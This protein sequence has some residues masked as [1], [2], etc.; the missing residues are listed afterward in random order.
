MG[1]CRRDCAVVKE[2]Y[3]YPV[4][5]GAAV[6]ETALVLTAGEGISGD[7]HADGGERQISLLSVEEKT[8]MEQQEIK[9]FCFHK[10]KEN[11]LLDGICLKEC[12]PG[13]FLEIGT[14]VLE[15]TGSGKSCHRELCKLAKTQK[16]CRLAGGSLFASVKESGVIAKGMKVSR[17]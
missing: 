13:D 2:L 4:K 10:Y 15:I 5:K 1:T 8:W 16:E 11:I 17:G 9:G 12:H 6:E 7:C 3:R 14:A